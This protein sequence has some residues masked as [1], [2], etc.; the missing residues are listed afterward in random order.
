MV[1]TSRL[2]RLWGA[3]RKRTKHRLIHVAVGLEQLP[4]LGPAHD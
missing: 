3:K 2:E 4:G 1:I